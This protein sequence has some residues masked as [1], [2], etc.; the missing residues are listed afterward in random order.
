[1]NTSAN[2]DRSCPEGFNKRRLVLG[3]FSLPLYFSLFLFLPAGTWT[4]PKG[5]LFL[6]V[7]LSTVTIAY[8]YLWWVNPR[9]L[10]ARSRPHKGSKP[11]DKILLGFLLPTMWA[12]VP[13]AALDVGRFQWSSL[14]WWA[15]GIG[16]V[17]L[18]AGM[19][20][21]TWAA[22]VNPY[23]EPTVRLQS[24]RGH[25]VIATGPYS[26]VRH[27]GYL[28]GLLTVV[29]IALSFG[30]LGALVPVF[31]ASWLWVL[32]TQWEDQTLQTEL[33]GYKEYT[34]Q[35]RHKLIPMVW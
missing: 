29:G 10:I 5:W 1:M 18:L 8:L 13:V 16:Y 6:L 20:M 30:S 17:L 24:D 28:G 15:C 3:L 4:W 23:F 9:V 7:Y 2:Q 22:G 12:I 27:P 31:L 19:G 34:R 32:R 14:P 35:V 21:A 25:H 26:F 33:T 11:W